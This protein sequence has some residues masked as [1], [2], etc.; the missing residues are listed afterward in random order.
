MN[1]FAN[2][3]FNDCAKKC[4]QEILQFYIFVRHC[5]L[6][7]CHPFMGEWKLQASKIFSINLPN[8]LK[9]SSSV[10]FIVPSLMNIEIKSNQIKSLEGLNLY[11]FSDLRKFVTSKILLTWVQIS[12]SNFLRIKINISIILSSTERKYWG[13]WS[14][15]RISRDRNSTFSWGRNYD[16]E[17]EIAIFHEI[18]IMIMRSKVRLG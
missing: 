6:R 12:N 18:E 8:E 10:L 11:S 14:G 1:I 3:Q 17:I 13:K 4:K 5:K 16:H 9:P 2:S 15:G 7:Y